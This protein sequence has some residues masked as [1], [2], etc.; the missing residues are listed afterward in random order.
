[1]P[2]LIGK[3]KEFLA[4]VSVA[5]KIAN[6][7]V[8]VFLIGETGTGKELFADLIHNN[9]KRKDKPFVKMN[10]AAIQDTL[11]ES[12]LFGHERGAF[13]GA[14][15]KKM[16]KLQIA[17]TGTVFFDEIT[18]MSSAIQ[19]KILR[20]VEYQQFEPVGG[21]TTINTDIRII[22]ATNKNIDE[23]IKTN[24]FRQDLFFRLGVFTIHIPPL[25]QRLD[26]IPLLIKHFTN[27]FKEK[28]NK[29][30]EIVS[31]DVVETLQ[32]YSWP[33]NIREFRN[34]LE[35]A[36]LLCD[37]KTL[38][39]VSINTELNPVSTPAKN[40]I[41]EKPISNN[42]FIESVVGKLS[43]NGYHQK[44]THAI[45]D[46]EKTWILQQLEKHN[47]VQYRAAK[48]MGISARMLVYKM[49]KYRIESQS[50]SPFVPQCKLKG[51]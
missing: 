3:N 1:M 15:T 43:S 20:A 13:T 24:Q 26:D 46:I 11:L 10:C 48:D 29:N 28:H 21:N 19:A 44:M 42:Q 18:N 9:S 23:L 36:V 47:Y 39:K 25:R 14:I 8:P 2:N 34:V 33:G 45:E 32:G 22:S 17:N 38:E 27:M 49:K 12:D 31:N 6:S 41:E 51:E 4:A 5:N 37:T 35:R 40:F 30:I 50:P 16:G 7:D